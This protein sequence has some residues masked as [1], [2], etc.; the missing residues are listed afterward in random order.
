MRIL[1]TTIGFLFLLSCKKEDVCNNCNAND[2]IFSGHV[3]DSVQNISIPNIRIYESTG[4]FYPDGI[5][6]NSTYETTA[7]SYGEY[8]FIL[9]YN[10][11]T[12]PIFP[13][14]YV[15]ACNKEYFGYSYLGEIHGEYTVNIN[16]KKFGFVRI[17]FVN[18]TSINVATTRFRDFFS[19]LYNPHLYSHSWWQDTT[20]IRRV[21]PD[22][23]IGYSQEPNVWTNIFVNS[24]DTI[25]LLISY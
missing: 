14:N 11:K 5:L 15:Y 22:N 25:D 8:R 24:G 13:D 9:K 2:L 1:F 18:D 17:S 16:C 6:N 4:S 3:S 10:A 23:E 21:L 12:S 20:F 7:D 19:E